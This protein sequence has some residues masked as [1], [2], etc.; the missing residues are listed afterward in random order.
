MLRV[1]KSI[2]SHWS[3]HKEV[4][5]YNESLD[6]TKGMVDDLMYLFLIRS[7]SAKL[8]NS[9]KVKIEK[10]TLIGAWDLY[11]DINEYISVLSGTLVESFYTPE[12]IHDLIYSETLQNRL[13]ECEKEIIS[14]N[15]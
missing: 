2:D 9:I 10:G 5:D 8:I 12:S 11:L 7:Q 1:K 4:F 14:L 6:A 15:E 3:L 13:D